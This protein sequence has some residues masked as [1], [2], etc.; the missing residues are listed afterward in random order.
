[1]VFFSHTF[2]NGMNAFSLCSAHK[3]AAGAIGAIG[4]NLSQRLVPAPLLLQHPP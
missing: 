3:G 2:R 1:M 4:A